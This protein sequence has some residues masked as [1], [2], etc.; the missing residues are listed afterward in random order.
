MS[1]RIIVNANITEEVRIAIVEND[2]LIDIDIEIP[3]RTKQKGNIFKGIVTN[4]EDGLEAAFVEFG[5]SKQAFLPLS[6]IKC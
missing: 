4:I 1:K 2:K 5:E 3:N 6:E